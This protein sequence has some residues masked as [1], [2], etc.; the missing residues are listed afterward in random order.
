MASRIVQNS[1]LSAIS[2]GSTLIAGFAS[3]VIV[4]RLLGTTA[5]GAIAPAT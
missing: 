4:A 2:G 3:T 5:T 1:L